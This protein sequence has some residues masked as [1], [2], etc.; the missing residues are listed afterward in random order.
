LVIDVPYTFVPEHPHAKVFGHNLRISKKSA[1]LVCAAIRNKPLI[2]AKRLL[3]DLKNN[4]RSLRG[5]YYSKTVDGILQLIESCERNAENLGLDSERLFVHASAHQGRMLRRR[6]RKAAFGSQLKATN[7]E[8]MLIE[9][10]RISEEQRK[11]KLKE[12]VKE[13]VKKE[14]EKMKQ[15]EA[16]IVEEEKEKTEPPK[17]E[18]S[19][20]KEELEKMKEKE[21]E[22]QSEAEDLEAKTKKEKKK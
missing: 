1:A 21:R 6:R 12:Q 15:K 9:R 7:V 18:V 14:V 11:E 8:I 3:I 16:I 22:I 5:K 20:M 13:T 4:R 10:G 17:I 2:R 19:D